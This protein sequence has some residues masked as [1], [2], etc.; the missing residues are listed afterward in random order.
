MNAKTYSSSAADST[1][2][3]DVHVG[4]PKEGQDTRGEGG[5]EYEGQGVPEYIGWVS[6]SFTAINLIGSIV[7]SYGHLQELWDV[8]DEGHDGDGCHVDHH[9]HGAGQG[10]QSILLIEKK[11]NSN[12]R[13]YGTLDK[14]PENPTFSKGEADIFYP[15]L[16]Q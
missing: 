1:E 12:I 13:C 2:D 9:P 7:I 15:Q 14:V 8:E 6:S 4:K 5:V 10:L 3:P 16:Y 11:N